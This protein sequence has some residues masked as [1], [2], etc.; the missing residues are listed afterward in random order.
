MPAEIDNN[1][2]AKIFFYDQQLKINELKDKGGLL[3]HYTSAESA[4][5]ILDKQEVWLRNARAMSDFEELQ[6]GIRFL[7]RARKRDEWEQFTNSIEQIYPDIRSQLANLFDPEFH[8]VITNQTYLLC[9]S[10]HPLEEDEHGRLSMWRAYGGNSGV[11]LIF[12][13]SPIESAPIEIGAFSTPVFYE[14]EGQFNAT[15]GE[16]A[17]ALESNKNKIQQLGFDGFSTFLNLFIVNKIIR[18]KHA[19]FREESEWRIYANPHIF[20]NTPKTEVKIIRGI[21]QNVITIP[22]GANSKSHNITIKALLKRIII[23]PCEFPLL[24]R[25]SLVEIL[26]ERGVPNAEDL[27]QYSY[28]PLRKY[29]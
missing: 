22:L 26:K 2:L 23:G 6:T 1:L 19:G 18:T 28:I 11:A 25:E 13:H 20:K 4:Y 16:L 21:P 8:Q 14:D 24:V 15:F 5:N 3:V 27:V 29:L 10:R 17:K 12:D 9:V 7:E